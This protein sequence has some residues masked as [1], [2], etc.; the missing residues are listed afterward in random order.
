MF[1]QL[2]GAAD[3]AESST[4]DDKLGIRRFARALAR[5]L[6]RCETP[7]TV[8]VQGEWGSGKT[9]LMRMVQ[10]I[11]DERKVEGVPP[12]HMHTFETWQYGAAG[13]DEMLGVHLLSNL[14]RDI[15]A[16]YDK[17]GTVAKITRSI[18]DNVGN[19]LKATAA[20]TASTLSGGMI[21]PSAVQDQNDHFAQSAI[22]G[23]DQLREDFEALIDRVSDL[24]EE[25]SSSE[26]PGRFI[27]FIDDLDRIRPDRAV[28]LLEVLKNFME[29]ENCVF[30]LACDYEVVRQGV[31]DKFG[32]EDD[33]KAR[34][35]FDKI[36]QVPFQMPVSKYELSGL[37]EDFI[38]DRI[39]AAKE[40]TR[41]RVNERA[42]MAERLAQ[43]LAPMVQLATGPNP[44]SFKRFLNT[45]DLLTCVNSEQS[46][47]HDPWTSS[48]EI[49]ARTALVALQSGWPKVANHIESCDSAGELEAALD[50]LREVESEV[51]LDVADNA[52]VE[53]L[54]D[55]YGTSN[56]DKTS[57]DSWRRHPRMESL[58][59]F[60]HRLFR[61]LDKDGD[62]DLEEEEVETILSVAEE[63]SITSVGQTREKTGWQTF[64]N[65]VHENATGERLDREYKADR[66]INLANNLWEFREIE[67]IKIQRFS[68]EFSI[69]VE[70]N[71]SRKKSLFLDNELQVA[72]YGHSGFAESEEVP[73]EYIEEVQ[74]FLEHSR[75]YGFEWKK[76]GYGRWMLDCDAQDPTGERY[77]FLQESLEKLMKRAAKL[78]RE[79]SASK[80]GQKLS[81]ATQ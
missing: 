37:F 65:R 28:T 59:E 14:T 56:N 51:E 78:A 10:E 30:V 43:R 73:E 32:I 19:V 48:D 5:F 4:D 52:L 34:A 16:S 54:R 8:G 36:V 11:L 74:E 49:Y 29:V 69:S 60:G 20:G 75:E 76:G 53:I 17:D 67:P 6:A 25:E 81:G 45:L 62:G 44:R 50:T 12:L 22:T 70:F 39:E 71:D 15:A 57:T 64:T 31:R 79:V 27:I 3:T 46:D 7:L 9:T 61:S 47:E 24:E 38:V 13:E 23:I 72:L 33:R 42:E 18:G 58:C 40:S 63:L 68:G 21:D 41:G 26:Q 66:F 2:F 80:N 1:D 77:E 35:F 55:E